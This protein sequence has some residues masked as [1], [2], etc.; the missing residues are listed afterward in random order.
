[1]LH[2]LGPTVVVLHF[3][4]VESAQQ[5]QLVDL[6]ALCLVAYCEMVEYAVPGDEALSLPLQSGPRSGRAPRLAPR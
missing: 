3:G 2:L 4:G 6:L 1:M 5:P